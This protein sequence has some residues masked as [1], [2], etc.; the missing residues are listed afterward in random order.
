MHNKIIEY[1]DFH[2]V[3]SSISGKKVVLTGGC[4]D[5]FHFGH[6]TFLKAAKKAGDILVV[7]V[8]SDEFIKKKKKKIPVHTQDQRAQI[9]AAFTMTDYVV[10][11]PFFNSD[12]DYCTLVQRIKP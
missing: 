3:S 11:L 1:K 10:K 9:L 8:E 12:A 5:I 6:F 7:L 2:K 4:F